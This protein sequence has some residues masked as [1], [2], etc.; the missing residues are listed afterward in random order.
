MS[1][2]E[3]SV[4]ALEESR[5]GERETASQAPADALW[6]STEEGD[7]MLADHSAETPEYTPNHVSSAAGRRLLPALY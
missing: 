4:K 3:D 6:E 5:T 7:T 1:V 2:S